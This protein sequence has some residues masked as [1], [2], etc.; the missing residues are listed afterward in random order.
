VWARYMSRPDPTRVRTALHNVCTPCCERRAAIWCGSWECP[1]RFSSSHSQQDKLRIATPDD[2]VPTHYWCFLPAECSPTHP[3]EWRRLSLRHISRTRLALPLPSRP[4]VS[5][6]IPTD[7]CNDFVA[8][9]CRLAPASKRAT[10]GC[11]A[12]E[13]ERRKATT[14]A[15][16]RSRPNP[17][18]MPREKPTY[19][20]VSTALNGEKMT[21]SA[22]FRRLYQPFLSLSPV[23]WAT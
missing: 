15:T 3:P 18:C 7:C 22:G 13:T 6:L 5:F 14:S 19:K 20:I 10:G 8:I 1:E 12:A 16:P 9:L 4:R 11:W 2:T 23:M 17:K 21:K